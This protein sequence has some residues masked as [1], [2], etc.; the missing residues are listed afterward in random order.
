MSLQKPNGY[1]IEEVGIGAWNWIAA[2]G[3]RSGDF[4]SRSDAIEDAHRDDI[5]GG[6]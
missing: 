3:S 4:E 5:R 6:V 1:T 2:D